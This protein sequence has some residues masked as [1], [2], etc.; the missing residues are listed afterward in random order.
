MTFV[1]VEII[2]G[3]FFSVENTE[4]RGLGIDKI[5]LL[6]SRLFSSHIL[7]YSVKST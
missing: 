5:I 6:D 2:A 3:L 7:G 4:T 1:L